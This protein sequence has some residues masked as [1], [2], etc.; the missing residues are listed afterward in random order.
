[1]SVRSDLHYRPL[2]KVIITRNENGCCCAHFVLLGVGGPLYL[3]TG[4]LEDGLKIRI[5]DEK[6]LNTKLLLVKFNLRLLGA[7]HRKYMENRHEVVTGA[8]LNVSCQNFL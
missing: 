6:F 4:R 5:D 2:V 7:W 1:M 8:K 3:A